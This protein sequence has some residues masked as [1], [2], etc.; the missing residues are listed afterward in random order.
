MNRCVRH[1]TI[2]VT[3]ISLFSIV[4]S[5]RNIPERSVRGGGGS[6]GIRSKFFFFFFNKGIRATLIVG[7]TTNLVNTHAIHGHPINRCSYVYGSWRLSA[8]RQCTTTPL[9]RNETPAGPM[10]VYRSVPPFRS[11]PPWWKREHAASFA[12]SFA[13]STYLHSRL[14]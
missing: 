7:R 8:C 2:F 5:D 4:Q 1:S 10:P 13:T 12:A 14:R 11:P 3:E 6:G 9:G